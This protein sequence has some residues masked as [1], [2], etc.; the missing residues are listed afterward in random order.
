MFGQDSKYLEFAQRE[1]AQVHG[2][3][4]EGLSLLSR[5]QSRNQVDLVR[6]R[7]GHRDHSRQWKEK[8][9]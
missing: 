4:I 1:S 8:V 9:T 2:E 5:K 3:K 6:L 7:A